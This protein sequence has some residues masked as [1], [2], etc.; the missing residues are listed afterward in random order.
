MLVS[1][2]VWKSLI[3]GCFSASAERLKFKS[4]SSM[5]R[6][7]VC[8]WR[9]L[10]L[11]QCFPYLCPLQ[12]NFCAFWGWSGWVQAGGPLHPSLSQAGQK[13]LLLLIFT[14]PSFAARCALGFLRILVRNWKYSPIGFWATRNS[15]ERCFCYCNPDSAI[16]SKHYWGEKDWRYAFSSSAILSSVSQSYFLGCWNSLACLLFQPV[17][18]LSFSQFLREK[19]LTSVLL[20]TQ[21]RGR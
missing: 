8:N 5:K 15:L 17:H 19:Y 13:P 16:G 3:C 4:W 18:C 11:Q 9:V 20:N 2:E 10:H 21:S 12:L 1:F 7:N 14:Q 6:R